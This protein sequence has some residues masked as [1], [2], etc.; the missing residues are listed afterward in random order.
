[1]TFLTGRIAP[2]VRAWS[3]DHQPGI[4]LT[5]GGSGKLSVMSRQFG[6]LSP[7]CWSEDHKQTNRA[8]PF[9]RPCT[10]DRCAR[11]GDHAQRDYRV[12]CECIVGAKLRLDES[13]IPGP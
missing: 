2:L 5:P 3:P 6:K 10:C 1:V 11:S 9:F 13:L 12:N 4:N 8:H 7:R